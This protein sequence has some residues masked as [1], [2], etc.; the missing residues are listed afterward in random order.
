MVRQAWVFVVWLALGAGCVGQP[1]LVVAPAYRSHTETLSELP[2]QFTI[3]VGGETE[4]RMVSLG[5]RGPVEDATIACDRWIDCTSLEGMLRSIIKPE[6][7]DRDKALAIWHFVMTWAHDYDG[8]TCD[9]PLEY[10][11]VWGYSYCGPMAILTDALCDAAGVRCR[12]INPKS[13]GTTEMFWEGAWHLL[14]SS[15][16]YYF[17]CR[18]NR[19]IASIGDLAR[20]HGLVTRA[21]ADVGRALKWGGDV[22]G[23]L[24]KWGDDS[25][26]WVTEA[27][28]WWKSSRWDGRVTLRPGEVLTR[29]WDAKR[30]W[31]R[32]H[33]EK[34]PYI[35]ATGTV[36]Y[37]PDFRAVWTAGTFQGAEEVKNFSLD[38]RTGVLRPRSVGEPAVVVLRM[39]T[40]YFTPRILVTGRFR[41][42]SSEARARVAVSVN[43]GE[44]WNLLRE[45]GGPGHVT[46]ISQSD[47]TQK[48]T[49]E[50][51]EKYAFL[52][53]W[54]LEPGSAPLACALDGLSV[55]ADLQYYPK[56]LPALKV[57]ANTITVEGQLPEEGS[58]DVT[59]EWLED[60]N[61]SLD[62]ARPR[63]GLPCTVTGRVT[64]TGGG[65]AGNVA[66][67][68]YE[69]MLT[70]GGKPI[71]DDVVIPLLSSGETREVRVTWVPEPRPSWYEDMTRVWML[72]DPDGLIPE[73]NERN[74][75]TYVDTIVSEKPNLVLLDPSFVTVERDGDTVT[76]TA[77][78]RNWDLWGLNP[79]NAVVRDVV[80]RFYDGDPKAGG[81]QI[82]ADQVIPQIV[83]GEYGYASVEWNVAGLSGTH[84]VHVLVDPDQRIPERLESPE[85]PY[86]EVVKEVEL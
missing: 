86:D 2:A 11:N 33:G 5:L 17:L 18:D 72:V 49:H 4:P 27:F 84:E 28:R 78:V 64:N 55:Q 35:Y 30:L 21:P 56:A 29:R 53:R 58:A 23:Q 83:A 43:N 81:M 16:R 34:P 22:E 50:S 47:V 76:F 38:R 48:V 37:A 32:A 9:D 71:A 25:D 69:G 68:F 15:C 52:V 20:D 44:T 13:H 74:N 39:H 1:D 7:S 61:I 26:D 19:T 10:A 73:V 24:G 45:S 14:D 57:G 75:A 60:L 67:R 42:G 31:C 62:P 8:H 66:V 40:P 80:V 65:P 77:A 41:L 46:L 36:L 85:H 6:L 79:G 54:E 3:H 63:V 82:G 59:Y 12:Y 70:E 51:A